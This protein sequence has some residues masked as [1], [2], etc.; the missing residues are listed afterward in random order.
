MATLPNPDDEHEIEASRMTLG[1]HLEELRGRLFKSVIALVIVFSVVYTWRFEVFTMIQGPHQKAMVMLNEARAEHYEEIIQERQAAGEE[2]DPGV[3][4]SEGYPEVMVLNDEHRND[5]RLVHFSADQGFLLRL[6]ICFWVSMFIS[7]PFLL[8]Q[9]WGFIAAGLY[10]NEKSVVHSYLPASLILF[11]GGVLFGYF[12]M[13]PYALYFLGLDDL[14]LETLGVG[15]QTAGSY[16]EFLKALALAMG[17]VFQLPVIM[18]ALTK[19]DLVDA[20]LWPTYRRHTVIGALVIAAI[21]TP[22]D[23]ITQMLMAVPIVILYE[24]GVILTR[25]AA[26]KDAAAEQGLA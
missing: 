14:N 9:M 20:K 19:L 8:L 4:F 3:W 5:D 13:V 26:R 12:V 6:R 7:G 2:V 1:E 11:L 24:A 21:L 23:P 17:A 10:R 18:L 15:S 16:L 22:P 25:I